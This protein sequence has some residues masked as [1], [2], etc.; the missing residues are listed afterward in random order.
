MKRIPSFRLQPLPLDDEA[1]TLRKFQWADPEVGNRH[2]LGGEPLL[3]QKLNWPRCP[4]CDE[5]MTFYGQL[6][7]IND[8]FVIADCGMIY[9]F[10]C[11]GCNESVARVQSG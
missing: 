8:D 2:K 10:L 5:P 6:D 9:V 1:R 7:S 11:F 4:S 3:L